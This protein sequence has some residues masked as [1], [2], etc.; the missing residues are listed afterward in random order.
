MIKP[1]LNAG[2]LSGVIATF[3]MS[4]VML[5]GKRIFPKTIDNIPPESVA[6]SILDKSSLNTETLEKTKL[7]EP[8]VW[9]SHFAYGMAAGSMYPLYRSILPTKVSEIKA[10]ASY[11]LLVWAASYWG[12]LPATHVLP[13]PQ[14]TKASDNVTRIVSHVVW[15]AVLGLCFN[16]LRSKVEKIEPLKGKEKYF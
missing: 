12:W 7:V 15:G 8:I 11:G 13:A 1:S 2:A 6:K 16:L 9:S 5:A 4:V 3:P 10:G 14:E